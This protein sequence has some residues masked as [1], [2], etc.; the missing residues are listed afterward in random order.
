MSFKIIIAGGGTGGHIFPA[1]AIAQALQLINPSIEILFVGAKGK[2]EM[3]K[4]PQAGFSIKGL[5]IAGFYRNSVFK[6]I[7]LPFKLLQSFFQVSQ[8]FKNFKPTAVIGVG[9]YSSFPVLKFAQS[10]KIP[11]FIHESNSFAGKSNT[12][13]GKYAT[14]I[15]VAVQGMD[16]FFPSNKI[17][18]SGNPVRQ[19]IVNS[20]IS[21]QSA[22]LQFDLSPN[23]KTLLVIGGSL[24]AKS[25][26][27]AIQQNLQILADNNI[28][29]IWQIGKT[30]ANAL[31]QEA[32]AYQNIY[33]KVFI[34]QMEIAYAAA[35]VVISRSGAMAVSELCVLQKPVVFVPY[36]F[37]AEDHQTA[38][39]MHLVGKNA[40]LLVKDNE[41]SEKLIPTVMKLLHDESLQITLQKNISQLAI[42]N[43]DSIIATE[44]L[45]SIHE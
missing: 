22:L 37:A 19:S 21:K 9:G 10:K 25:I 13:L 40:A 11:T 28:Q 3:E 1:I 44:I 36:P 5:T 16:K 45:K 2:M 34:D 20:T 35:D 29:L 14:K 43:A 24:G 30:N 32:A 39:A 15:F 26:N 12:L 23:K 33:V 41:V 38:N 31:Q 18:I 42:I 4:I 17:I 8:I 7:F 27:E 6:N